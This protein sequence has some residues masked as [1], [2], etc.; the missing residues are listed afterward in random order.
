MDKIDKILTN[1]WLIVPII[2]LITYY[3]CVI[4]EPDMNIIDIITTVIIC[5][6]FGGLLLIIYSMIPKH[7]SIRGV[8]HWKS[9]SITKTGIFHSFKEYQEWLD[10]F[11]EENYCH[12][13]DFYY[14]YA[15][16]KN[17]EP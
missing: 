5:S 4:F 7:I 6:I 1:K 2:A 12:I 3:W 15:D 13:E 9:G 11:L 16:G 8:I 14:E 17:E 10:E